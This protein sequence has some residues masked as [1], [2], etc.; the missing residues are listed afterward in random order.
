MLK[1][2]LGIFSADSKRPS[3][4]EIQNQINERFFNLE[5]SSFE[6]KRIEQTIDT[7]E[8][9]YLIFK[10]E[11]YAEEKAVNSDQIAKHIASTKD[12]LGYEISAYYLSKA[13][14]DELG[15]LLDDSETGYLSDEQLIALDLFFSKR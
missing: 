4:N 3:S 13:E 9:V 15:P 2:E 6:F 12:D 5:E 11:Y 1:V 8:K 10:Y 7:S 14:N